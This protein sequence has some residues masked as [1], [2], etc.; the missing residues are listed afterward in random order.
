M[1][2]SILRLWLLAVKWENRIL[3]LNQFY[4]YGVIANIVNKVKDNQRWR[5]RWSQADKKKRWMEWKEEEVEENIKEKEKRKRIGFIFL[6][7]H[8]FKKFD[9]KDTKQW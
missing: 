9:G 4:T 1:I 7:K 3:H 6:L 5:Q 8:L 2:S